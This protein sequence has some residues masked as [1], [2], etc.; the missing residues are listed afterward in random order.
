MRKIKISQKHVMEIEKII[1]NQ[2]GKEI[3]MVNRRLAKGVC[4]IR[5]TWGYGADKDGETHSIE[6]C[7]S[8]YDK[9]VKG[10]QVPPT[11][12]A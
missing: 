3:P 7:E 11:I 8:C 6:L 2:C 1:C 5:Q 12:E 4:S 9:W 10:F